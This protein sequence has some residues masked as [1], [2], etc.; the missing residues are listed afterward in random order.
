MGVDFRLFDIVSTRPRQH[1]PIE[2]T[3]IIALF[4]PTVLA[5]F[6]SRTNPP[7]LVETGKIPIDK[8]PGNKRESG[9][10]IYNFGP[11]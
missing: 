4:I 6:K 10:A 2:Q 8:N 9:N 7:A 3:H 11:K 1:F 5:E